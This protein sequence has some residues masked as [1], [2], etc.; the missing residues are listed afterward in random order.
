MKRAEATDQLAE[1]LDA[2]R[3]TLRVERGLDRGQTFRNLLINVVTNA[4]IEIETDIVKGTLAFATKNNQR[5]FTSLQGSISSWRDYLSPP[6]TWLSDARVAIDGTAPLFVAF[7][8]GKR[9]LFEQEDRTLT[10]PIE[11]DEPEQQGNVLWQRD[12]VSL[13]TLLVPLGPIARLFTQG[14][15]SGGWDGNSGRCSF[16]NDKI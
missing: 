4:P 7:E 5:V 1:A 14:A 9:W 15:L 16:W 11:Q 8:D 3:L 10:I 12:D 13:Q 6:D 2:S